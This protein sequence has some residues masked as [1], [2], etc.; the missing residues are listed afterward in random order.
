MS[1]PRWVCF[2]SLNM[3]PSI[4]DAAGMKSCSF[5]LCVHFVQTLCVY[6]CVLL[7]PQAAGT[8]HYC[9][10]L[11]WCHSEY[12]KPIWCL[13]WLSSASFEE[14]LTDL[15][16]L[17]QIYRGLNLAAQLWLCGGTEWRDQWVVPISLG[18]HVERFQLSHLSIYHSL[19]FQR[20]KSAQ[21][22]LWIWPLRLIFQ[23]W[24][25]QCWC[26]K[27]QVPWHAFT[28]DCV[29]QDLQKMYDIAFSLTV[30]LADTYSIFQPLQITLPQPYLHVI[31]P[32]LLTL[33]TCPCQIH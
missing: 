18:S 25:Y 24:C 2:P 7:W 32:L 10:S 12:W 30:N 33:G 8:Y 28:L 4:T 11:A 16:N 23:M 14:E 3:Y 19:W 6:V 17:V 15:F 20:W 5:S 26:Y 31:W 21:L 29:N 22:L 1:S 27:S 13:M 9:T